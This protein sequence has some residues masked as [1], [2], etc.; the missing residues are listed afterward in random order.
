MNVK[1]RKR[2]R[3]KIIFLIEE[4]YGCLM[5]KKRKKFE[6]I[7]QRKVMDVKWKEEKKRKKEVRMVLMK[8]ISMLDGKKMK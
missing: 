3:K 1:W 6:C 7:W 8:R 5:K 2:W 4:R